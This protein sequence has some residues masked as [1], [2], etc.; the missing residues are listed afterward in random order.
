MQKMHERFFQIDRFVPFAAEYVPVKNSL[1]KIFPILTKK[2]LVVCETFIL[3]QRSNEEVG[4][5]NKRK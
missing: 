2:C 4:R 3:L 1:T 5:T